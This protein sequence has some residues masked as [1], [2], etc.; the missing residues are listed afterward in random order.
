MALFY[1]F[2]DAY[3]AYVSPRHLQY[4]PRAYAALI[5]AQANLRADSA[6]MARAT[7]HGDT[8]EPLIR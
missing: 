1:H 5:T 6:P 4:A 3:Y 8:L 2:D 7:T